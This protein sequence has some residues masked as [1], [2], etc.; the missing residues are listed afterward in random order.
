LAPEANA[1]ACPTASLAFYQLKYIG[2]LGCTSGELTFFG[3]GFAQLDVNGQQLGAIDSFDIMVRPSST[4]IGLDFYGVTDDVF[5]RTFT[6]PERYYITYT[7]DPPPIVAGDELRLDPPTGPVTVSRWTCPD[8][9]GFDPANVNTVLNNL[10]MSQYSSAFKCFDN[11]NPY[12]LQ[13]DT[14][15]LDAL[16]AS[17]SFDQ[18]AAS[19][20]VRMVIDFREGTVDE[21]EAI[22]SNTNVVPEPAAFVPMAAGV[23]GLI[24]YVRR[25]RKMLNS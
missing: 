24:A 22:V 10:D 15:S 11:S 17:V 2:G 23:A 9:N 3:F 25:R 12:F 4:G 13:V 21:L 1:A 8:T 7:V 18:L 5:N 19:V 6:D 16:D 20:V 14:S